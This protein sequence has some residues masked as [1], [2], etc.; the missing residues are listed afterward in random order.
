MSRRATT[1]Q[2][3]HACAAGWRQAGCTLRRT[4]F[5]EHA[6]RPY[7]A[8]LQRRRRCIRPQHELRSWELTAHG[9]MRR[10]GTQLQTR[11]DSNERA[12]TYR[13][14]RHDL[15]MCNCLHADHRGC[16]ATQ[17]YPGLGYGRYGDLCRFCEVY[18]DLPA[19]R[20]PCRVCRHP[21]SG[22]PTPEMDAIYESW[23]PST[24][25][26]F[27]YTVSIH[28]RAQTVG[29]RP[30]WLLHGTQLGGKRLGFKWRKRLGQLGRD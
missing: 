18:E 7:T 8:S 6:V 19:C 28:I 2:S 23:I 14:L 20:C 21:M 13:P 11:G 26:K 3:M 29:A 30:V 24:C 9:S 12:N 27:G 1:S 17:A 10:R 5:Q 25:Y 16:L 22:V 15:R 4:V